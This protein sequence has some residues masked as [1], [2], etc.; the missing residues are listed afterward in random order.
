MPNDI[1]IYSGCME[2][3]RH[4]LSIADTLLAGRIDTGHRDLN[5]E[6]IFLHFRKA[7]EEIAFSSL[8]ANREKYSA[9]R[10]GFATEW[11]A[12][13]MLVAVEKINPNFFPVALEPPQTIG[14]GQRFF[15][16][17]RDGFLTQ[18]EFVALYDGS[19]K[20]LHSQNPYAPADPAIDGKYTVDEWSR[21][22][23]A[24]LSWHFVQLVDV[25]E[26]W[27]VQVPN[28][29]AVQTFLAAADGPFVVEPC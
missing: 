26:L 22:I 6:L 12:K 11:S 27:V 3:V 15:D 10:A 24:L 13:R 4:H 21:R 9:A 2:R 29:G 14:G 19:S 28:E 20:I 25:H 16:R 17:V 8:S 18:D 7:L 5:T 1:E 23:K